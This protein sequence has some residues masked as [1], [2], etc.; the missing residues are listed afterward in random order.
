VK[1]AEALNEYA[2]AEILRSILVQEQDHLT[3]LSTALG[4]D[5]PDPGIA[6]E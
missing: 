5:L 3:E 2:I 1:Q 4:I 6:D